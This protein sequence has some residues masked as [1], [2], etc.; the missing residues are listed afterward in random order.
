MILAML[1]AGACGQLPRPFAPDARQSALV[2]PYL[3]VDGAGIVVVAPRGVGLTGEAL[4][5]AVAAALRRHE[6][7]ASVEGGNSGSLRLTAVLAEAGDEETLALRWTLRDA[8]GKPLGAFEHRL[9]AVD[10]DSGKAERLADLAETTAAD[11]IGLLGKSAVATRPPRLP[12]VLVSPVSGA[13]GD[14][15]RALGQAMERALAA[16]GAPLAPAEGDNVHLV[17]G[18]V[19]VSDAR[20]GSQRVEVVWEVIAPDGRRLG[21][22]R[23]ENSVPEGALDGEWGSVA[24]AIAAGGA[25]GVIEILTRADAS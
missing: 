5:R 18:G 7:P 8:A 9:T 13:P 1:A 3:P 20:S 17:R 14:G 19:V 2:D 24:L 15:Q 10:L 21:V 16:A 11:V 6:V 25:H 23:Q 12:T 22:V 4:A